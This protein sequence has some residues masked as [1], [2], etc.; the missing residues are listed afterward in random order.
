MDNSELKNNEIP[1]A[2]S[3]LS[4]VLINN[5]YEKGID[6]KNSLNLYDIVKNNTN[7]YCD[8]QW[9]NCNAPDLQK[10]T[11]NIIKQVVSYSVSMLT[12]DNV[13]ANI[14][15]YRTDKD[16]NKAIPNI[17]S[18]EILRIMENTQFKE[19]LKDSTRDCAI[20]GD[21]IIYSYWNP[22]IK[23]KGQLNEGDIDI[24]LVKNTQVYFGNPTTKNVQKQPFIIISFR[25]LL[26]KVQQEASENGENPEAIK[27]DTDINQYNSK[28]EPDNFVT[29]LVYFTKINGEVWCAKCTKDA[30]VRK[31]WNL[32]Y[33]LYPIS[34]WSWSENPNSCHGISPVSGIIKNQDAINKLWSFHY[35]VVQNFA[36]P[37]I[38]Y[39]RDVFGQQKYTSAIGKPIGVSG[40]P[41]KAIFN[42]FNG[43]QV[44]NEIIE[45][46]DKLAEKS[47][48]MMGASDV[49][50]GNLK[51][52]ENTSAIIAVSNNS[53]Q[54]LALQ[55]KSYY[56]FVEDTFRIWL[57]IMSV[58]YGIREVKTIDENGND[59]YGNYDFSRLKDINLKL[60]VE[61]GRAAWYDE[62]AAIQ[63]I[64][65]LY[66][67][68]IITDKIL[69]LESLPESANIPNKS[70]IIAHLQKEK[71]QLENK[72]VLYQQMAQFLDTLP[73]EQQAE[74]KKLP[75]QQLE[76]TVMSM[77]QQAGQVP[78]Q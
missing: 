64:D 56:N 54:P 63:T 47:K 53:K 61:I 22:D 10:I 26:E 65:N 57:D 48:Q 40:D 69:Y 14:K 44:K 59:T 4:P 19:S 62:L 75:P 33:S 41:N 67:N 39:D 23:I 58:D 34:Y 11:L 32:E 37:K 78:Q 42:V 27:A 73:P 72:T 5:R 16:D 55:Q 12:T 77:M 7:Y 20:N 6:Y 66:H 70:E 13:G 18:S 50:L 60:N 17:I 31:P 1:Q 49:A 74:L 9:E 38:I 25:K 21:S 24:E 71:A 45:F 36:F 51:N 52:P 68:Q 28:Y 35:H 8:K 43:V 29:E 3:S 15:M 46:A 76:Q 30:W 2:I